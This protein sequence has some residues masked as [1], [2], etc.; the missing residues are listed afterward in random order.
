MTGTLRTVLSVCITA[1]LVFP[2]PPVTD[3]L[4]KLDP[5]LWSWRENVKATAFDSG[6]SDRRKVLKIE[7]DFSKVTYAWVKR[8]I[9]IGACAPEKYSGIRF[10]TK[11]DGDQA[12]TA[13]LYFMNGETQV[14]YDAAVTLQQAWTESVIPFSAFKKGGKS[15]TDDELKLVEGIMFVAGKKTDTASVM[16]FD[17]FSLVAK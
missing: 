11:R 10:F 7:S 12:F 4:E 6:D 2:Q 16:Y 14:K 5:K 3:D 9:P 15:M 8:V 17:D 13:T 1:F